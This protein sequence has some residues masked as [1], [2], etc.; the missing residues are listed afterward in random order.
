[1]PLH[2]TGNRCED[3]ELAIITILLNMINFIIYTDWR[4]IDPSQYEEKK[5]KMC[6]F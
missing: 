6:E 2:S 4:V 1:M 3:T 5:M